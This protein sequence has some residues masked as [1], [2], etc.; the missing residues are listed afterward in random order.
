MHRL[1]HAQ[2]DNAV[3]DLL[4]ATARP[5]HDFA[6]GTEEGLFDTMADQEVA[7]LLADQYLDAA[8][9]LAEGVSDIR[10]LVGCDPAAANSAT[11]VRDF[12]KRFGRR[13]FR[14]VL[15]SAEV[16]ALVALYDTMRTSSDAATGVRG[17]VAAVLASPNFLFRP[18]FG[19]QAA[20]LPKALK[21]APYELSAR[22]AALLWASQPDDALLDA[23]AQGQLETREQVAAQARRMLADA[24]ART[25]MAAFYQQWFGLG[26]LDTTTKDTA[27]YPTFNDGLRSAMFED[28]RRFVEYVLWE[29]DA[30]LSTLLTAPYA[31]VNGALAKVYGVG[32]PKDPASFTKVQLDPARRSGILTQASFLSAFAASNTS[33]PV[34]RGKWLRTRML[35]HELPEPPANIPPLPPPKEG[36]STR[37][38]FAMHTASPACSGCHSLIDGLGFGLEAYDGIGGYRTMDLGVPV[39]ARGQITATLDID[40]AYNGAA[41]LGALLSD[42]DQVL[43]CAPTQWF[44]YAFGRHEGPDDTCSIEAMQTAFKNSGGDL[45]ELMLAL[46]Q[47]DAFST[48][49]NPN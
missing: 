34:K 8:V 43:A 35:C 48:Y 29:D 31:F 17:V 15:S 3:R 49:R 41:E 1:T 16:D 25:G 10:T 6:K 33:S 30:K 12:V 7:P 26:L 13:A 18:E 5:G 47:T 37:E 14:R 28:T 32:A 44:R 24:K 9:Q 40:G 11:C 21:V 2:Y 42:S 20:S 46:V 22:L 4:G 38:R 27:V 23:A 36:I 45:K 39:D 19:A